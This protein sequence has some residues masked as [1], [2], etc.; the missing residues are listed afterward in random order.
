MK[1]RL[2][3]IPT[4]SGSMDTFVVH[5]RENASFP[6]VVVFMD[7]WGLREELFDIARRIATVG[8]YCL[9]PN[10]YYRQGKIRHEFRD[11][12]GRMVS[13]D[14]LD[15]QNQE[16]VLAPAGKLSDAMVVD[17]AGALLAFLDRGEPA[18]AGAMGC[19]GYCM[20]GRH[21]FRAAANF[22]QRFRASISLHGTNL[23]TDQAD[24]PHLS[25]KNADGEVYCGF[26][27]KDRFT[28]PATIHAIENALRG[29]KVKFSC[30]VHGGADHG[31]ALPDR[32]VYD[33]SAANR[34]WE[35][36]FRM[37][38]RQLPSANEPS[39]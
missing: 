34:D 25:A 20:G 27:E 3:D 32:D 13:L 24:S 28:P 19:I 5:P 36:I 26:G 15:Q 17:D 35:L 33:K 1:E 2:V 18:R 29:C 39:K 14:R 6:A 10:F 11:Q 4:P 7:V 8:Y 21:V 22:P 38:Q 31:Y 23:V 16:A 30:E 37:F 9:V 12:G